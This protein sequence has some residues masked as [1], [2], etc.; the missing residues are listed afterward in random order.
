MKIDRFEVLLSNESQKPYIGGETLQGQIE[1]NVREKIKIA[2]LTVKLVGQAQTSWRNKDSDLTYESNEQVLNEYIDLTRSL[3]SHCD[4]NL[5]LTE[6]RHNICFQVPLPLDVISSIEKEGYGWVRYTC[7]AT[8][9]LPEDETRE[10]IAERNFSV[11]SVL[12]LDAPYMRQP[13]SSREEA[14][15]TGCCCKRKLGVVSAQ[16]TVA[17]MGLL[18][19]ETVQITLTIENGVKKR[20][21]KK[22]R[23]MA[24]E[25]VLIS[26]CQQLDFISQNRYELHLYDKKSLTIAVES[27]GTCKASPGSGPETKFIDFTIPP[28]LQPTSTRAN[29]LIT[30]SYFFKLDMHT[31]D[32]IVPVIIGSVKTPDSALSLAQ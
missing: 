27:H 29:G 25:C 1:I 20:K 4:D 16:M 30:I 15:V 26:L 2:R 17:D 9:D 11:C 21:F 32:V 6:G 18:P 28:G 14:V 31:F 22:R 10:M 8:L 13:A 19:G 24:R 23:D 12:N 5:C 3:I 7:I